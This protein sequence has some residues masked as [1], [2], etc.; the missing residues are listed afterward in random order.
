MMNSANR[1]VTRRRRPGRLVILVILVLTLASLTNSA[2]R[3]QA[4]QVKQTNQNQQVLDDQPL[5]LFVPA[6]RELSLP[7]KKAREAIELQD[8]RTAVELLGAILASSKHG[9]Y[10]QPLKGEPY[11]SVSIHQQAQQMMGQIPRKERRDYELRF[12]VDARQMLE[13]AVANS[14]FILMARVSRKFFYTDPGIQATYL[15]GHHFLEIGQP[16]SAAASFQMLVQDD[17][18]REKFDPQASILLA[19]SRLLSDDQN[20]AQEALIQLAN[21]NPG[22]PVQFGNQTVPMFTDT[23]AAVPWLIELI[24]NTSLA[25]YQAVEDWA[26][27]RGNPQRNATRGTG[28]PLPYARWYVPTINEPDH[29][30]MAD[31]VF[32]SRLSRAQSVLPAIQPVAVGDTVIVRSLDQMIGIDFKSGKRI[33]EFPAWKRRSTVGLPQAMQA[34]RAETDNWHIDQRLFRDNLYG[35]V[36]SDGRRVFVI[37]RPGYAAPVNERLIQQRGLVTNDPNS[38]RVTNELKAVDIVR[39][40]AFCWEVGGETG[41][42]VPELAG[43]FFLGAPLVLDSELFVMCEL[44]GEIRLVV[45]DCETGQLNWSQQVAAIDSSPAA[46]VE[47]QPRRLAAATPSFS[48][49]VIVCSTSAYGI[50]GIERST[51]SLM[52]GTQFPLEWMGNQRDLLRGRQRALRQKQTRL[53]TI[54]IDSTVTIAESRIVVT[55]PEADR[56][57]C[58]DLMTGQQVWEPETQ[59]QRSVS[60]RPIEDTLFVA[61]IYG[62]QILLVGKRSFRSLDLETGAVRWN[63][64]LDKVGQPSG[65]GF[66]TSDR[67]FLPTANRNLVEFDIQRGEIAKVDRTQRILGN[68]ICY[69]GDLISQGYDWV[70]VYRQSQPI[71]ERVRRFQDDPES[72]DENRSDILLWQAQ[73][74]AQDGQL[75]PAVQSADQAYQLTGGRREKMVLLDLMLELM[76]QDYASVRRYV[77]TYADELA[78]YG[79]LKYTTAHFW[80][81]LNDGNLA[82]ALDLIDEENFGRIDEEAG[83][84]LVDDGGLKIRVDAQ[85]KQRLRASLVASDEGGSQRQDELRSWCQTNSPE[86]SPLRLSVIHDFVGIGYLPVEQLFRLAKWHLQQAN[87]TAVEQVLDSI[88][89]ESMAPLNRLSAEARIEAIRLMSLDAAGWKLRAD[90]RAKAFLTKWEKTDFIDP[91]SNEEESADKKIS[92]L[93]FGQRYFADQPDKAV[94]HDW[95]FWGYGG[96]ESQMAPLQSQRRYLSRNMV[97]PVCQARTGQAPVNIRLEVAIQEAMLF[98]RDESGQEIGKVPYR[99]NT[100][101][102]SYYPSNTYTGSYA[103]HGS[104]MLFTYAYD[105]IAVDLNLLKSNQEGLLWHKNLK[106]SASS[107]QVRTSYRQQS[108]RNPWG[109]NLLAMK[110]QSNDFPIGN[111]ASNARHA[112]FRIGNSIQAVDVRTGNLVWQRTDTERPGWLVANENSV[113]LLTYS[114]KG[115]T[116]RVYS[117]AT[118]FD[119]VSGRK[120]REVDLEAFSRQTLWHSV[121]LQMIF[122]NKTAK[123][124]TLAGFDLESER[125]VW[126]RSWPIGSKGVMRDPKS[127]VIVQP[128]GQMEYVQMETGQ[129][130]ASEKLRDTKF[131]SMRVVPLLDHDLLLMDVN[132]PSPNAP[133]TRFNVRIRGGLMSQALLFDGWVYCIDRRT[134]KMQWPAAVR[135]ESFGIPMAH[136]IDAPIL[137]LSRVVYPIDQPARGSD[138]MVE[139]HSLDLRDGRLVDVQRIPGWSIQTHRIESNPAE[140]TITH[141]FNDRKLTLKLS[142][143]ELPPA[144]PASLTNELTLPGT[145]EVFD[146]GNAANQRAKRQAEIIR[147]AQKRND[148]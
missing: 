79:K 30:R 99:D 44:N 27:F 93:E 19:T 77:N 100:R 128:E 62:G 51:R 16:V 18:A 117:E 108:I 139:L 35:Q 21:R 114:K 87:Y 34:R 74:H 71:R 123:G 137:T 141:L 120:T 1:Q 145:K 126:E 86:M 52:W 4:W 41:G 107:T 42:R 40:G 88:Q 97:Q 5:P 54:S 122:T 81:L 131:T 148:K 76:E 75:L 28:L 72:T 20:A 109:P 125:Q 144:A 138:N 46:I 84:Q 127:M 90:E 132:R 25:G 113:A 32:R 124:Q 59:Q 66:R 57:Y 17:D 29:E 104:L 146:N 134:G 133:V 69:K 140:Q 115:T 63:I 119:A 95:N 6:P 53:D 65:R 116:A 37:D 9:D 118:L 112:F 92:G 43:C 58:L 7:L 80:G 78:G 91:L 82:E 67:Y 135:L 55:P 101:T 48:N 70:S 15:L 89:L 143:Q 45:L 14:D 147:E 94:P 64:S 22:R 49:G 3:V 38:G 105:M 142:T 96:V 136:P 110:S 130:S 60:G 103:I 85:L 83:F 47:D 111:F 98:I 73:L 33:W 106:Q 50:V 13:Q 56:V 68:L 10:L 24:G 39:Q 129:S 102:L 31:E 12:E 26:M 11:R 61:G 121:G 8:Y 23:D 36:A 2:N